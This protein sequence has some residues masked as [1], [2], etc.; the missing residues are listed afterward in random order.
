MKTVMQDPAVRAAL[1]HYQVRESSDP[2]LAQRYGVEGYPTFV[3][4]D[5]QGQVVA[6]QVGYRDAAKFAAWLAKGS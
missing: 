1:A 5:E 2:S 3:I 4:T 6:R